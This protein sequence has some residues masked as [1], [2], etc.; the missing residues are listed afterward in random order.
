MSALML[1]SLKS[2]TTKICENLGTFQHIKYVIFTHI[3]QHIS[4]MDS[5]VIWF[6]LII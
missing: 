5:A 4:D 6:A 3:F 2:V 1:K